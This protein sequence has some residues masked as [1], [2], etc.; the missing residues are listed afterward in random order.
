[1]VD[2]GLVRPSSAFGA[3]HLLPLGLR[4]LEKLLRL[5]DTFMEAADA[6]KLQMPLL[7]SQTLWETTG[8]Q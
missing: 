4:S 5:V 1:M 3:F 8:K 7:T 6:Q 2:N